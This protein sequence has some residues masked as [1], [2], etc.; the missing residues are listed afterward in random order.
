M[1]RLQFRK[2]LCPE[3]LIWLAFSNKTCIVS[4]IFSGLPLFLNNA[5]LVDW[6]KFRNEQIFWHSK[7]EFLWKSWMWANTTNQTKSDSFNRID[8]KLV[9][10]KFRLI[11][12]SYSG[13]ILQLDILI[14]P[15]DCLSDLVASDTSCT[16]SQL[17]TCYGNNKWM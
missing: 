16:S 14:H 3:L 15:E 11:P 5:L 13:P 4:C 9:Y 1:Y 12:L 17:F 2:S 10:K 8:F 7:L 6:T